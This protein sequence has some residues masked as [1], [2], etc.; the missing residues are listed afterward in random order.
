MVGYLH[1]GAISRLRGQSCFSLQY[2]EV[3]KALV[4]GRCSRFCVAPAQDFVLGP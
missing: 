3:I 4:V 2:P 1:L